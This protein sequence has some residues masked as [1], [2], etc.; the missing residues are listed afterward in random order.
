[1]YGEKY[2]TIEHS[3]AVSSHQ[4]SYKVQCLISKLD[5]PEFD[6]DR[7]NVKVQVN[8]TSDVLKLMI[9]ELEHQVNLNKSHQFKDARRRT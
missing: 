6:N 3:V 8:Y 5:K 1:M 9:K 7:L 4:M 2:K